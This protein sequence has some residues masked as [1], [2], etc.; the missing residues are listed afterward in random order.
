MDSTLRS[1]LVFHGAVVVLL[2]LLVGFP[3][4]LVVTGGMEGS[5]RAWRMAHLE[6]VLNGM[7]VIAV[8]A[9]GHLLA[10]SRR[11]QSVLGGSLV[12]MAYGNVVAATLGAA[13]GERGLAPGISVGNTIVYLLFVFAVVAV[14]VGMLLVAHGARGSAS[15]NRRTPVA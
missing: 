9:G 7:L 13:I 10:L 5:E 12:L 2:G 1:R 15:Q 6:G 11:A 4:G 14:L 8:G 3:Y